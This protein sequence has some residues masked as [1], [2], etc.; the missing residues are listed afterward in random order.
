MQKR[1][2][3]THSNQLM[4]FK[5]DAVAMLAVVSCSPARTRIPL[6]NI[7]FKQIYRRR[8]R[9]IGRNARNKAV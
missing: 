3:I 4:H 9:L 5:K 7:I 8:R 6:G 2:S 1:H